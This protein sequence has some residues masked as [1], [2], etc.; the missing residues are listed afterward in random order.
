M[1]SSGKE[2]FAGNPERKVEGE[3]HEGSPEK[4]ARDEGQAA[5]DEEEMKE[6]AVKNSQKSTLR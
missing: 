5:E 6:V 1:L 2:K 3:L 4:K